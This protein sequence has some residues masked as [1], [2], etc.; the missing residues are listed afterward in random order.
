MASG[1]R[2]TRISVF[3][4]ERNSAFLPLSL[5]IKILSIEETQFTFFLFLFSFV[6]SFEEKV[7]C[8]KNQDNFPLYDRILLSHKCTLSVINQCGAPFGGWLGLS[9]TCSIRTQQDLGFQ[10]FN[11]SVCSRSFPYSPS[12]SF[13][14]PVVD[15]AYLG[16]IHWTIGVIWL[17]HLNLTI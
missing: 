7:D 17:N 14:V 8:M 15:S 3:V 12:V 10:N 6:A 13:Y 1:F 16:N 2:T 9:S 4:V 11:P 5:E